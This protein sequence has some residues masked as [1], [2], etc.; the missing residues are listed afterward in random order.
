LVQAKNRW[1]VLKGGLWLG[2]QA[3]ALAIQAF[4]LQGIYPVRLYLDLHNL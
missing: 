2:W 1:N 3:A 4:I